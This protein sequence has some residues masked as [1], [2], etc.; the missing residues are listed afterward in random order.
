MDDLSAWLVLAAAPGV[1]PLQFKKLVDHYGDP[2]AVVAA[3][4]E[5]QL[6]KS[7]AAA[8]LYLQNPP[9]AE[10][11]AAL[12]W[13]QPG[14]RDILT[15]VHPDYPPRLLE[16]P[17]PPPVIYVQGNLQALQQPQ[18][19]IVGSRNPSP[20]G[21]DNAQAFAQ[22]LAGQGLVITSGLAL[23]IDGA[24]HTGALAAKKAT[25]A[26]LGCGL[27]GVYPLRHKHLA[28]KI[29]A[30]GG[31]LVSELPL[32]S[33]PRAQHFP[34]RNRI[35][36]GLSLGVLIVEAGLRSGSLIT[37]RYALEQ[38]REV[39]ALPGGIHNPLA[40]GTNELIRRGQAKLV[41][42]V[43]HILEE[44]TALFPSD[45]YKTIK[46][47]PAQLNF[48]GSAD[49]NLL[50]YIGFEPIATDVIIDRSGLTTHEVL[51]QLL[52]L[53]LQG[54]IHTTPGGHYARVR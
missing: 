20:G 36:S 37:A 6:P 13:R 47:T 38:G 32:S 17:A 53:E 45:N 30:Q 39:Y 23:G 8:Q 28:Q 9:G 25:V 12:K 35:I 46:K 22:A 24:A 52:E 7:V 48:I 2:A 49:S 1:G 50:M 4:R 14:K 29:V 19:A 15:W 11:E 31:A 54:K 21:L 41:E 18:V 40:K 26:V 5:G 33:P 43:E 44:L 10:I 34:R 51:A 27:H 16:I 3:A 42:S